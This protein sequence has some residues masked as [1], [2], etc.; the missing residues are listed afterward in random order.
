MSEDFGSL[1]KLRESGR[2]KQPQAENRS[3][4]ENF[5][6]YSSCDQAIPERERHNRVFVKLTAVFRAFIGFF[7]QKRKLLFENW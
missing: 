1:N 6:L 3:I 2:N 5:L 7:I 4:L